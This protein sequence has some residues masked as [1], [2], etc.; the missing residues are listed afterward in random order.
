[1]FGLKKDWSLD[2][3][4]R[5]FSLEDYEGGVARWCPGCGD[6]AVLSAV[7]RICRDE[8]LAPEKTVC[9]SGIGCSSR[10]PHYMHT[11]GFHGLHGRALPVACGVKARRPDLTIWVATGDGDC[12]SIG[13]G[14]WIHAIRYNMNMVVMLFDN[15]V[16][17]LTKKQTSPTTSAGTV[18]N[19]HPRGAWLPPL[20]P[21]TATLGFTNVSF[22]AKTVDWNPVHL[23]A[24]LLKAYKHRGL[25]FVHIHQR[26]P[27]YT[28]DVYE[29]AQKDP[30]QVL[31]LTDDDGITLDPSV[32]RMYPNKLEHDPADL[33][34]AL[35]IAG[36]KDKIPIGLLFQDET[37][38]CYEDYMTQGLGMTAE[39]KIRGMNA[40]LDRFAI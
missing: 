28:A 26:C 10:F 21:A 3:L 12:C 15:N 40:A 34:E 36:R 30:S 31:L 16:Y 9:V 1:M 13:A 22:V 11:Y 24:T 14:H 33:N 19:T 29:E 7:Q 39:E 20:N 6:H 25:S 2:V 23:H 18:T 4:P 8:Q 37:R 5:Y 27:Q 38:P 35:A 32:A 17:G